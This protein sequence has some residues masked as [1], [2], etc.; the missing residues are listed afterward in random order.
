[1]TAKEKEERQ[2]KRI[3]IL[4]VTIMMAAPVVAQDKPRVFITGRG[5][6]NM[7]AS[8][9]SSGNRWFR[10][11]SVRAT[12]DEHDESMEV[13]KDLQ[14]GCS[15]VT[16][17]LNQSFADYTVMLARESKQNRGLLRTNSQV[18]VVNRNGDVLDTHATRTVNNA[19]KDACGLI[20]ADWSQHGRLDAPA[21]ALTTPAPAPVGS[22]AE[23]AG[24]VNDPAPMQTSP[25][26]RQP[27]T[28]NT[29]QQPAV[30]PVAVP[31]VQ[32]SLGEAAKRNKQ[33]R[34]C[35]ALAADN[36]SITCR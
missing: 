7:T 14:R 9:N 12:M 23:A 6:Q 17:T 20:L 29:F 18:Q 5:S 3:L 28:T 16:I 24:S 8:G 2:M 11:G 22:I 26:F 13:A 32:E 34:D 30:V 15:G 36:P 35:L 25:M 19:A 1:M 27:D 10:T 33:H 4:M 31:V 21:P